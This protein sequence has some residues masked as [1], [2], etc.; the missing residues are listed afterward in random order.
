[1]RKKLLLIQP[2]NH[3]INRFRRRQFNNFS[4]IT[5]PYLAGFVDENDFDIRLVDEYNQQ[6]PY[7][8]HFDLV[9]ITVN[10]P[11]ASHCYEISARFRTH[12]AKVVLGG[13]HVTLLPEEASIHCDF[14][15]EGECE[16]TWPLFLADFIQG[17]P[18]QRYRSTVPPS[19]KN[20]PVPRWDLLKRNKIMK[21]AVFATRGCP[22]HCSYCNLK[23]I[24]HASFRTRPVEEVVKEI[25]LMRSKFFVFWDDNLFADKEYAEKLLR[26]I[27]PL[28]RKWAAQVTLRDCNDGDELLKLAKAAGC[29][30]LFVGLE[31]FSENALEDAGKTINRPNDYKPLIDLIHRNGIM[32]QAGIMFGFDSDTKTVF[33]QTLTACEQLGIDGVTVSILT[34]FPKTPIYEQLK[35][36]GRLLSEDWNDYNGKTAIT[37]IPENMSVRELWDGYRMFRRKF[38]TTGSFI[39]RMN[40]SRTN[41]L[42]NF[43][44]NLGYRF[45]I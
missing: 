31:S 7:H 10:T 11:N 33:K 37:F 29:L 30:Y 22:Y 13:P 20:L 4:Q 15:L 36:E 6:I 5:I 18:R 34:P 23:Q 43:F 41:V 9:G 35:A 12:G 32:I 38:Y 19:L 40:V 16:E 45:G 8:T 24:Y 28:K 2:E 25:R 27:V 14:L 44:I 3:E 42:V 17:N 21:G 1:M 39:R 26:A